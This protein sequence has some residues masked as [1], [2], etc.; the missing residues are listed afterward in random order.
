MLA[1]A[2]YYEGYHTAKRK[3]DAIRAEI[4]K[5]ESGHL[6]AAETILPR[7]KEILNK[8]FW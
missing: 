8:E 7:V 3:L 6:Y 5:I 4:D 2:Y 1:V